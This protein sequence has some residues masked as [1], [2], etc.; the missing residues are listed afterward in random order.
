MI[1]KELRQELFELLS[2][3]FE[4]LML[5]TEFRNSTYIDD[6]TY[7]GYISVDEDR[8][9]LRLHTKKTGY[10]LHEISVTFVD[11]DNWVLVSKSYHGGKVRGQYYRRDLVYDKDLGIPNEVLYNVVDAIRSEA[12][13]IK[14]IQLVHDV[15][16]V[17]LYNKLDSLVDFIDVGIYLNSTFKSSAISLGPVLNGSIELKHGFKDIDVE[18]DVKLFGKVS[19]RLLYRFQVIKL[20]EELSL[21]STVFGKDG[22]SV[23]NATSVKEKVITDEHILECMGII[24]KVECKEALIELITCSGF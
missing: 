9:Y 14:I 19:G 3:R 23:V 16:D 12:Q 22:V 15:V 11:D 18:L 5:G 8:F 20:P 10:K 6:G 7:E 13:L 17:E 1:K 4:K 2:V 24:K 21:V